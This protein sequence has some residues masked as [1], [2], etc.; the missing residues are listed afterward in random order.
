MDKHYKERETAEV[1]MAWGVG[2][3]WC[4]SPSI[5]TSGNYLCI[6]GHL[7]WNIRKSL[8]SHFTEFIIRNG[9]MLRGIKKIIK[10]KKRERE[11]EEG[12]KLEPSGVF[13][14]LFFFERNDRSL[15]FPE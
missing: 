11:G 8:R 9:K 1:L 3:G 14:P 7:T 15:C 12:A 4:F 2:G 13:C 10:I 5:E 6:C